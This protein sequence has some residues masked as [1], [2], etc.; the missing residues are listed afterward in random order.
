MSGKEFL[1]VAHSAREIAAT[2][3]IERPVPG[4]VLLNGIQSALQAIG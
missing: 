3:L 4:P 1:T 2:K